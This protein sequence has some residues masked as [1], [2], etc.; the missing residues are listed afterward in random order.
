MSN[1]LADSG[2]KDQK[3]RRNGHARVD[4]LCKIG[5]CTSSLCSWSH[6]EGVPLTR[7]VRNELVRGVSIKEKLNG[8]CPLRVR[9]EMIK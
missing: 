9:A 8:D 3:A 5:K 1:A 6:P 7:A 4:I 2:E